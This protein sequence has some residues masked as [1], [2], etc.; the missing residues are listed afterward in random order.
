[1]DREQAEV[2]ID[3]VLGTFQEALD[4]SY[5]SMNLLEDKRY[6]ENEKIPFR[7]HCYSYIKELEEGEET[8]VISYLHIPHICQNPS[9]FVVEY[10]YNDFPVFDIDGSVNSSSPGDGGDTY[11]CEY[12]TISDFT[13][14]IYNYCTKDE[15]PFS[16][17]NACILD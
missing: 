16:L 2:V 15:L 7:W 13:D 3:L 1:M 9:S 5:D 4:D 12:I 8:H 17:E 6:I 10:D 11:A 14:I